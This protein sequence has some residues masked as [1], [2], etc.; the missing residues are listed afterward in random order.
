MFSLRH[1]LRLAQRDR[2]PDPAERGRAACHRLVR[3]TRVAFRAFAV[4]TNLASA[5]AIAVAALAAVLLLDALLHPSGAAR[6]LVAVLG[7]LAATALFLSAIFVGA[8]RRLS[9]RWLAREIEARFPVLDG[10]LLALIS[11]RGKTAA[12]TVIAAA[13]A[14]EAPDLASRHVPSRGPL[15]RASF[16]ALGWT[17]VLALVI[18]AY[19][20]LAPESLGRALSLVGEP[21]PAGPAKLLAVRPGSSRLLEGQALEVEIACAGD[22]GEAKLLLLP[23]DPGLG[24]TAREL[25]IERLA[26]GRLRAKIPALAEDAG[27]QVVLDGDRSPV[28]AISV[29]HAPRVVAVSHR[30][31]PPAYLELE[32]QDV[33]GGDIDAIEGTRVTIHAECASE[34]LKG[35]LRAVWNGE[36][37]IES[38]PLVRAGERALEGSFVARHG[39]SYTLEYD[40]A[41]GLAPRP[42][43]AFNIA[44]RPDLPPRAEIL[45]PAADR[46]VPHDGSLALE[47]E[48]RDDH[49]LGKVEL[50]VAIKGGRPRK[51]PLP[52]DR[53]A[54]SARGKLV[55]SPRALGLLPGDSLVYYVVAED[56]KTPVANRGAS[57]PYV[58][59]VEENAALRQALSG[60]DRATDDVFRGL[61]GAPLDEPPPSEEELARDAEALHRLEQLVGHQVSPNEALPGAEDPL[62]ELA[63]KDKEELEKALD[64]LD[65]DD[66]QFLDTPQD[67]TKDAEG[68]AKGQGQK[69]DPQ[70]GAPGNAKG[71][72]QRPV[73]GRGRP[74]AGDKSSIARIAQ[75][76]LVRRWR[77]LLDRRRELLRKLAEQVALGR[78]I[79]PGRLGPEVARLLDALGGSA[80]PEAGPTGR[81]H[82]P[83]PLAGRMRGDVRALK[84]RPEVPRDSVSLTPRSESTD[85]PSGNAAGGEAPAWDESLPRELEQ[86][87]RQYFKAR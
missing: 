20:S 53:N 60:V 81:P 24:A 67:Q 50:H 46:E 15:H 55:L 21:G 32:A 75:R 2:D 1:A 35:R 43:A 48:V 27:Y 52:V 62:D 4:L 54:R 30:I 77:E 47:Y 44:V 86:V 80:P 28:Y 71:H 74:A 3:R 70:G 63:A 69:G 17:C 61:E 57:Q 51:L 68:E 23:R 66:E 10:R 7:A 49:G 59:V 85:A 45:A 40:D 11:E 12:G 26:W 18:A 39:G 41:T 5:W 34:P 64:D 14:P 19:A 33:R 42:S 72:R 6:A 87:V 31:E 36:G 65:L 84:M 82:A 16:H 13:L 78:P 25:R 83:E 79:P 29:V 58:L 76:D 37:L 22:P 56:R 9:A 73:Q 38:I 8:S